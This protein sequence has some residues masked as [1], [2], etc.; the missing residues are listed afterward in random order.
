MAHIALIEDDKN[1]QAIIKNCME[2][3]SYC[4]F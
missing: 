4:I 2:R 1:M 3:I